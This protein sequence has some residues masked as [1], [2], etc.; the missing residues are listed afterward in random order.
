MLSRWLQ[1][2]RPDALL[3]NGLQTLALSPA[4]VPF[5][6]SSPG[7]SL[8]LSEKIME[9]LLAPVRASRRSQLAF[10]L[11]LG[12][13]F[14]AVLARVSRRFRPTC[15]GRLNARSTAVLVHVLRRS[16]TTFHGDLNPLSTAFLVHVPRRSWPISTPVPTRFPRRFQPA[17]QGGGGQYGLAE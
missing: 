5:F 12:P 1:V 15:F 10:H 13:F 6:R 11:G 9:V 2:N 17:F 7:R 16:Q 14:T 4:P 3:P 8:S